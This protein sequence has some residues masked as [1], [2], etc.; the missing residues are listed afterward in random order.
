MTAAQT[1]RG[2][3]GPSPPDGDGLDDAGTGRIGK[4]VRRATHGVSIARGSLFWACLVRHKTTLRWLLVSLFIGSIGLIETGLLIRNMVDDA[5]VD[6]TRPLWPYVTHIMFWATWTLVFTFVNLQLAERLSYSIEFDLRTWLYTRIQSGDLRRLDQVASGQLVSRSI[7][8]LYLVE[9]LLKVFPQLIAAGPLLIALSIIVI[10]LN[11]VIGTLA[12]LALP[13]NLLLLRRF[14]RRLRALSWLE[15]N[16]R[17]EVAR[18]IDEPVRG[19][20]VVKAFGREDKEVD[21]LEGVTDRAYRFSMGRWRLLARYDGLLK[22]FPMEIIAVQIGVGAWFLS[23]GRMTT[24][25]FVLLFQLASG[26]GGIARIL[27]ELSS[28]WQYLR[29][30]QDRLAEML[31]LSERPVTDGRSV[32]P[33]STGIELAG[34]RVRYDR[35]VVLGGLSQVVGPGELVAFHGRPATGK[36]TLAAVAAG[37]L[38]PDDGGVWLNGVPLAELDP[39]ELRRAVRV[40]AEEPLLLATT[41]RDNLLLG[42]WGEISDE[43]LLEALRAA[44]AEDVVAELEGGLDGRIGD[45]GL[46]VSGGQRQRI[47]LARALVAR[48]QVLVLDDALSAVNPSLEAEILLRVRAALP[49]CAIVFISR[50]ATSGELADRIVEIPA[51]IRTGPIVEEEDE[52]PLPLEE[53]PAMAV[54]SAAVAIDDPTDALMEIESIGM[55]TAP[56]GPSVD[57]GGLAQI[58]PGLASLIE[59]V[60]LDDEAP[61]VDRADV[62]SDEL[63]SF[64]SIAH[65]FRPVLVTALG[66]VCLAALAQIS[67]DLV[68]GL[69]NNAVRE[70]QGGSI[71]TPVLAAIVL[72]LLAPLYGLVSWQ[73]RLRAQRFTQ[74]VV[75]VLR[76][77][78]FKRLTQLGVNYYDRELPGDVATRVVADLDR[79]LNFAQGP[80]FIIVTSLAIAGVSLAAIILIVPATW[81]ILLVFVGLMVIVT[82]LEFRPA[83]RAFDWARDELQ[84]VTRLFQEDF[85][86][87]HELRHLGAHAIQTQRFVEACWERRRAR[88]WAATVQNLHSV[89]ITFLGTVM[90]AFLLWKT[91]SL[92]LTLSVTIG[93]ALAVQV[94]STAAT[95]PLQAAGSLYN[96]FVDARVSWRRLHQPFDEPIVPPEID[97]P[98]ECPPLDRPIRFEQVRFSYPATTR[99]VLRGVTFTLEPRKI[100]ALVGY[101]GAGKSS[102]AKLLMRTYD[103]DRGRV[104]IG[105]V[106]LPEVSLPSLRARLGIVPQDPFLFKGTI[107]SNIRYGRPDASDDDVV[108]AAHAVGALEELSTLAGGFQHVVEE[109]GH[110]LTA[111]QRQLVAL[112]RAWLARPDILVLDEATSLLDAT[113][114]D[115][116]IDAVHRLGCTTLMITHRENVARRADTIVVLE[117]GAVVD[118]GPEADVARPGGPYDRLWRVQETEAAADRDRE[119]ST[120]VGD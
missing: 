82:L 34:L 53:D 116:I 68:F 75:L 69:V 74:K 25:T 59:S 16:E 12:I 20:R 63:G 54:A 27:D 61:G 85:A 28:A 15:L 99:E 98:L 33:M 78:V 109:E 114:E 119:L 120:G 105:D 67:P 52:R 8:D 49:G 71:R 77:R 90:G 36:S 83:T 18:A 88:W 3:E 111:A 115:A 37:L 107:A 97:Q 87:R 110:N 79:V 10:I 118:S 64:W 73:A 29:G 96:Q 43:S 50:R 80:A 103:P 48:P 1:A 66:L 100:T 84:V 4:L 104:A 81:L 22:L 5:I 42:A 101:T 92:V 41:L 57:V 56:P 65:L 93:A 95:L 7:T 17:A 106:A 94:L 86:A 31:A 112:A 26:L 2:G 6:Q 62:Y 24:G 11:P 35:S 102:I 47:S 14:N 39:Q 38:A 60:P 32:P 76:R 45:R 51:P 40:A 21:R 89:V 9:Q 108:G 113:S 58:D 72:A 91:G 30:A 44:G 19:I 13:V 55:A 23:T 46:T 70:G 117:A